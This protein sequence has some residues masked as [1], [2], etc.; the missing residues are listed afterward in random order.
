MLCKLS[1]LRLDYTI[2]GSSVFFLKV[3]NNETQ[4]SLFFEFLGFFAKFVA[5]VSEGSDSSWGSET[6]ITDFHSIDSQL[7]KLLLYWTEVKTKC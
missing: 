5:C 1:I 6:E 4:F 3:R 7:A 2:N